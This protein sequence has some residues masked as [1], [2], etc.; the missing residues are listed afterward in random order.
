MPGDPRLKR[1]GF[2]VG[3]CTAAALVAFGLRGEAQHAMPDALP[4][5]PVAQRTSAPPLSGTVSGVVIDQDGALV[6]GALITLSSGATSGRTT[7]SDRNGR[8]VLHDVPPG[9]FSVTATLTGFVTA[10][11]AGTMEAGQSIE[12]PDLSLAMATVSISVQAITPEQLAIEELHNEEHQRLAGVLPNF[13]VS[14]NWSAPPLTPRQKFALATH[15]V[16]DPGNLALAGT[17]AG[18]QQA[19]DAFPGYRQGAAGYGKRFGA[20]LAN[21]VAG[22]YMGGA[23]LPSLFHQDPRYFYKGTGSTRSRFLYAISRA[24]ITRSDNGQNQPN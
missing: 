20:D 17:V 22:T 16:M 5:A 21:L 10:S 19:A 13:F 9:P 11:A 4:E 12:L 15:N 2:P 14:Y 7:F 8:F 1:L 6:D 3:P 23:V 24:V 18:I